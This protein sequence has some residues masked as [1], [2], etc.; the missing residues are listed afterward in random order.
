MKLLYLTLAS[1][2]CLL[3]SAPALAQ[4]TAS[5]PATQGTPAPTEAGRIGVF[6]QV[7]GL[8]W[9]GRAETRR[10]MAPGE[11]VL[12]GERLSTGRNGAASLVLKDGTVL[13][14]GPDTTVDLSQFQFDSTT[15]EGRF[16]L[17]LLQ[18]TLRVVT[19]L[20][21]KVNPE[22]F[23]I[24]TPTAVV[25]VRGT[26]FIVEAHDPSVTVSSLFSRSS[27]RWQPNE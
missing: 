19:G 7:Q 24:T 8:A 21:A 27:R 22:R 11:A 12:A 9:Q 4:V 20:L 14:L 18:G 6:K 25:G 5:T 10:A 23:R 2:G 15:Q 1:A 26:D 16:G 13:T 17:D 3:L